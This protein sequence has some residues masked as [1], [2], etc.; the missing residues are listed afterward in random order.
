[1]RN[2]ACSGH[3]TMFLSLEN[4]PRQAAATLFQMDIER[5]ISSLKTEEDRNFA[6]AKLDTIDRIPFYIYNAGGIQK[7]INSIAQDIR[8]ASRQYGIKYFAID[9]LHFFHY[10]EKYG[11]TNGL[12]KI[13]N[14]LMTLTREENIHI[15]LLAHPNGA[16]KNDAIPEG[17]NIKGTSAAKQLADNGISVFRVKETSESTEAHKMKIYDSYGRKI[18]IELQKNEVLIS[19]WKARHAEAKEGSC[20][21]EFNLRSLQF[22]DKNKSTGNSFPNNGETNGNEI[23][24]LDPWST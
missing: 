11:Q 23:S 2:V 4:G 7:E 9:H 1:M 18:N 21:L 12:D 15:F 3:P 6:L 5:P 16:V 14:A 8:L 20:I 17:Q 19:A 10:D 24:D 22:L 13:L